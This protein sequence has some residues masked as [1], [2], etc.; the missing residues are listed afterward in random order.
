MP[1]PNSVLISPSVGRPPRPTFSSAGMCWAAR[2]GRLHSTYSHLVEYLLQF[3]QAEPRSHHAGHQQRNYQRSIVLYPTA[4][5]TEQKPRILPC[6]VHVCKLLEATLV[7]NA[8]GFLRRSI[9]YATLK[10]QTRVSVLTTPAMSTGL[11]RPI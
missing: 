7:S 6:L 5:A 8:Q 1:T 10:G 11:R 4:T 3:S 9:C 2:Q